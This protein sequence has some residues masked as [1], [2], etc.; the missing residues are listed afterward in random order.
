MFLSLV[1]IPGPALSGCPNQENH[2]LPVQLLWLLMHSGSPPQQGHALLWKRHPLFTPIKSAT[3]FSRHLYYIPYFPDHKTRWTIRHI[4]I[5]ECIFGVNIFYI[6][7]KFRFR[8]MHLLN[9][10][11]CS[12][13]FLSFTGSPKIFFTTVMLILTTII[14]Q[15]FS[16]QYYIPSNKSEGICD[17]R[18]L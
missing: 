5:L 2:L 14:A 3:G 6:Y 15:T 1:P 8:H 17:P 4:T 9:K 11:Q 16:F 13:K 7:L 10:W 18:F 12:I